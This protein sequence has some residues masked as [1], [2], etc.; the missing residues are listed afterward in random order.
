MTSYIN[1]NP[2]G[3][4]IIS[5][6][7][8]QRITGQFCDVRLTIG[9]Q[10]TSIHSAVVC[11]ISLFLGSVYIES[12]KHSELNNFDKSFPSFVRI[13]MEGIVS[14]D[15]FTCLDKL[16]DFI[17]GST[18][19]IDQNHHSHFQSYYSSLN[20]VDN[21]LT[22]EHSFLNN[23]PD[24]ILNK[25]EH[26]E[27]ENPDFYVASFQNN[28]CLPDAS[29][30][31]DQ[32]S[33]KAVESELQYDE[34]LK[35]PTSKFQTCVE[36]D[37]KC[38]KARDLLEHLLVTPHTGSLCSLCWTRLENLSE[39]KDHLLLHKHPKPYFC[40]CCNS[41]F[42][43]RTLLAQHLPSHMSQRLFKCLHCPKAF[44]NRHALNCHLI[45]HSEEKKHLCEECGY[46]TLHARLLRTHKLSHSGNSFKCSF[47]N[48]LHTS[49]Y[50]QNMQDHFLIHS[51]EKEPFVCEL[52]G[53]RFSQRKSLKR[54][55]LIHNKNELENVCPH[56]PFK[57]RRVDNL[58]AHILRQHS[59][60]HPDLKTSY[61][62]LH[63]KEVSLQERRKI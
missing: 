37:F 54:H 7:R 8:K 63:S 14:F 45:T 21:L 24:N 49:I 46:S 53:H 20:I 39:L 1:K 22:N 38:Y 4:M 11:P 40:S 12:R 43:T 29:I 33:N 61:N 28:T 55:S 27:N 15:C 36:C 32:K 30:C 17:Y 31:D 44:K 41:R 47:P 25:S 52:C 60:K 10:H 18:V 59:G 2:G 42:Q 56:C 34:L 5:N 6:L 9:K 19:D 35:L 13:D 50:K 23:I 57:A 48:C 51:R 3:D 58:K 26:S 62:N 16:M